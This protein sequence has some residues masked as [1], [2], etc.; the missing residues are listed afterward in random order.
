MQVLQH[1][2]FWI[3]F[4]VIIIIIIIIKLLSGSVSGDLVTIT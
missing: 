4:I 3:Y 1:L 2:C